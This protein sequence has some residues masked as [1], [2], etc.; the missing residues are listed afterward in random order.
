LPNGIIGGTITGG[1]TLLSPGKF[2]TGVKVGSI[3]RYTSA[4]S[5]NSLSIALRDGEV[6]GIGTE[7]TL[8]KYLISSCSILRRNIRIH[9]YYNECSW[10]F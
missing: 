3:I 2:F 9:F 6:V 1:N 4:I 5:Q 7:L 10:S 8:P